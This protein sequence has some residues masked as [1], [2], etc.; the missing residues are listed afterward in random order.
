MRMRLVAR[1]ILVDQMARKGW[2]NRS[3][4]D[5][6]GCAPG[7]IDNLVTGR[8]RSVNG[9]RRAQLIS[10]ALGLPV[11][12]FF[13]PVLSSAASQDGNPSFPR[14]GWQGDGGEQTAE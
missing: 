4:A 7:T 8:T 12:I 11:E 13:V 1:D 5:F 14:P 2:T 9:Q 10:K 6:V 3:L